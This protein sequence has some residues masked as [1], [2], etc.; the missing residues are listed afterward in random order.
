MR[1]K[2]VNRRVKDSIK[3]LNSIVKDSELIVLDVGT[4]QAI[5]WFK[6]LAISGKAASKRSKS[7]GYKIEDITYLVYE[8]LEDLL[9][10]HFEGAED[11]FI[12]L[13]WFEEAD[14][15]GLPLDFSLDLYKGLRSQAKKS[16]SVL[17]Y[18]I[19][20]ATGSKARLR[21]IENVTTFKKGK[22]TFKRATE[23][24]ARPER[25]LRIQSERRPREYM[26][27]TEI[28]EQSLRFVGPQDRITN[29]DQYRA[30]LPT[31]TFYYPE[32]GLE[33]LLDVPEGDSGEFQQRRLQRL[34]QDRAA[35][36]RLRALQGDEE[37]EDLEEAVG[38]S[39]TQMMRLESEDFIDDDFSEDEELQQLRVAGRRGWVGQQRQRKRRRQH[40]RLEGHHR[41]TWPGPVCAPNIAPR[42]WVH[43]PDE[44]GWSIT[45]TLAAPYQ[46]EKG[47][48]LVDVRYG[49]GE[50]ATYP[51]ADCR[52]ADPWS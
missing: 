3:T 25:Q 21:P 1:P 20:E 12:G 48:W 13:E 49:R 52:S 27:D 6:I 51:L 34:R 8:T 23:E 22:T 10:R 44:D 16:E 14:S 7:G 26:D 50:V 2:S 47:Q 17:K 42:T 37:P 5:Q 30:G 39:D 18:L 15:I 41:A 36:Q 32:G 31:E 4:M 19:K 11:E 29:F 43:V 9:F 33:E 38:P 45:M 28:V 35:Q 24:L 40:P 46:D